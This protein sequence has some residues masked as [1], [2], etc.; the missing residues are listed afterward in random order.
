MAQQA[1]EKSEEQSAQ[2]SAEWRK[3]ELL[4]ALE[5]ENQESVLGRLCRSKTFWYL[6]FGGIFVVVMGLL[7][8]WVARDLGYL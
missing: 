4:Q 6:V 1:W 3:K 5:E 7:L 8:R 2:E